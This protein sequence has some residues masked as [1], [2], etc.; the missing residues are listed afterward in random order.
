MNLIRHK[1]EKYLLAYQPAESNLE[2]TTN[3]AWEVMM[4]DELDWLLI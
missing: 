3:S 4:L 2:N 1:K